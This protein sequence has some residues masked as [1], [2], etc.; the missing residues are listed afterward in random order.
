MFAKKATPEVR[1]VY[2]ASPSGGFMTRAPTQSNSPGFK[3]CGICQCCTCISLG[4]LSTATGV[5]KM[6]E[7]I[8]GIICQLLLLKYGME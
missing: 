2:I 8:F 7:F 6:V 1:Q 3:V 4:F 5:I